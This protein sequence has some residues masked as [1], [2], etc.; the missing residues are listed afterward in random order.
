MLC[1]CAGASRCLF[2]PRANRI[3]VIWSF[4]AQTRHA[5]LD[6]RL[7]SSR[8]SRASAAALRTW[9]ARETV[10]ELIIGGVAPESHYRQERARSTCVWI[11]ARQHIIGL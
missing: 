1:A 6:T 7:A 11:Y 2:D 3:A 10:V 5:E 4:I 8:T 9:G